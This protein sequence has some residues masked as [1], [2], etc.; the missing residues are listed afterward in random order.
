MPRYN[1]DNLQQYNLPTKEY[2]EEQAKEIMKKI[3]EAL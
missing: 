3:I 2:K 1:L